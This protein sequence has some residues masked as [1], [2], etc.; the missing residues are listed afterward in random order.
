VCV[1]TTTLVVLAVLLAAAALLLAVAVIQSRARRRADAASVQAA[2][3]PVEGVAAAR[4][5]LGTPAQV[6]LERGERVAQRLRRLGEEHPALS[7]AS[8]DA[9]AV[10]AELRS[11]AGD[12]AAL[13]AARV[14][15]PMGT[16]EAE[17][18]RLDAAVAD[19]VGSPAEADLRTA[20]DAVTARLDLAARHRATTD[21][22][23]ARMR[24]AVAG[25]EHA[26]DELTGL[27]A[28]PSDTAATATAE[29]S[30]RLAGLRAGLA[31]VRA[32]SGRV[33]PTD[34]TGDAATDQGL[35]G[36]LP[37]SVEGQSRT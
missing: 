22:L 3:R 16:L 8:D 21:A 5:A 24:A 10:V 37:G 34:R 4:P 32:I 28:A 12:V 11:A 1:L 6:W 15:L 18:R 17:R 26:A 27:F 13:D 20:R 31:E 19:A 29:L 35:P 25:L 7:G 36:D 2:P 9:E 14:R 33:V 30:D 23:L